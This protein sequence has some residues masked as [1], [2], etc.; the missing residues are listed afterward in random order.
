MTNSSAMN[1]LCTF[2]VH[3]P[4]KE[5]YGKKIR[6]WIETCKQSDLCI[7]PAK[8]GFHC[9]SNGTKCIPRTVLREGGKRKDEEDVETSF[10]S[11]HVFFDELVFLDTFFL[12]EID[13]AIWNV[14]DMAIRYRCQ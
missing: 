13:V 11:A 10:V 5:Y 3:H 7:S 6:N 9:A 4:R 2:Y 14:V 1:V 12:V 8:H